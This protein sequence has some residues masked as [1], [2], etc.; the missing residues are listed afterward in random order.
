[1]NSS[2]AGRALNAIRNAKLSPEQRRA[3]ATKASR[4]AIAASTPAQRSERQKKAAL[5]RKNRKTS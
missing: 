2:D 5:V 1:M 3:I 4:A